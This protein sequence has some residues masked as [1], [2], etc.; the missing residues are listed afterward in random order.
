MSVTEGGTEYA[1]IAVERA[2][3]AADGVRL[4][5]AT[6]DPTRPQADRRRSRPGPKRGAISLS[7]EPRPATGVAAMS[8]SFTSPAG[9]AFRGFGGRHNGI[10]QRGEEFL[11]WTQQENLSSGRRRRA[12]DRRPRAG[13]PTTS[14]P[15]DPT[16]PT[17]CSPR[18]SRP[19]A[20]A[21]CSTATRSRDWRMDSDRNDAWQVQA[22]SRRL[23]YTV[24]PGRTR[25][26]LRRL[27]AI[28]GRQH[29]PPR[30]ALGPILDREVIFQNDPPDKYEAEVRQRPRADRPLPP[31]SE[32]LP[33]RGLAV[34]AQGRAGPLHRRAAAARDPPDALLPQLRR[35]G[36]DRHRRPRRLRGGDP[37]RLRRH[38]AG[39]Q[40]VHVHLQLHRRTQRRSTSP[41][42]PPCAGGK[43]GSRPR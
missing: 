26:A 17:T 43:G 25:T 16:P 18:S 23:D 41:T 8:D 28:T 38:H 2:R 31:A 39:R 20:T 10:D 12:D 36:H 32:R 21:S 5:L 34:P 40:A 35:R 15:T 4:T 24:A 9:E 33:H 1:A 3:R 13:K 7:A 29:V 22:A 30:W 19:A 27:T 6:S 11:N 37:A 14:S 42:P